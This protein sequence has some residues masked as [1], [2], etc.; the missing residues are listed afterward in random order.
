MA[1]SRK[2]EMEGWA[3][4]W[5][6]HQSFT[7]S[8][9]SWVVVTRQG[10]AWVGTCPKDVAKS[11]KEKEE[12]ASGLWSH[13]NGGRVTQDQSCG[14][15]V[16]KKVDNL[17]SSH[18]QGH[19]MGWHVEDSTDKAEFHHK[20]HLWHTSDAPEWTSVVWLRNKLRSL[21]C[22]ESQL[23]AHYDCLQSSFDARPAQMASQ[24]SSL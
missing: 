6:G 9:D 16:A 10:R 22:P 4:S 2:I 7:T 12:G 5:P 24:S 21:W 20:V 3:S 23:S 17:R 13:Q 14:P 19:K 15:A 11:H 18:H 1:P 8:R